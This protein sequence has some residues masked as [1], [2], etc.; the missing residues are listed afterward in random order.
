MPRNYFCVV[1]LILISRA[2]GDIE[3]EIHS[4]FKNNTTRNEFANLLHSLIKLN[5]QRVTVLQKLYKLEDY[6]VLSEVLRSGNGRTENEKLRNLF[7]VVLAKVGLEIKQISGLHTTI[8]MPEVRAEADQSEQSDTEVADDV[9]ELLGLVVLDY[10]TLTRRQVEQPIVIPKQDKPNLRSRKHKKSS[11][12]SKSKKKS[13]KS[14]KSNTW[15]KPSKTKTSTIHEDSKSSK[16][17][18]SDDDDDEHNIYNKGPKDKV[19]VPTDKSPL[20]VGDGSLEY[21]NSKMLR[22]NCLSDTEK[23]MQKCLR[24]CNRTHEDVCD[25]LKCSAR[26]KRALAKECKNNCKNVFDPRVCYRRYLGIQK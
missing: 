13:K 19:E 23:Q 5:E 12:H 26:S 4:V 2:H 1:F 24:A 3:D 14:K 16:P 20:R 15:E 18:I 6:G 25:R 8:S 21:E 9:Y 11:H 22:S 7:L 10:D 17:I